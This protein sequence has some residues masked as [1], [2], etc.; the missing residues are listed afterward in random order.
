MLAGPIEFP[1]NLPRSE[2]DK[3]DLLD[4]FA[5]EIYGKIPN[6]TDAF[7]AIPYRI[8]DDTL[9]YLTITM[10]VGQRRF[11]VDAAL[12]IPKQAQSLK[13]VI[14]GLDFVGPAGVLPD[15]SF[16]LDPNARVY[17]RP[18]FGAS[19]GCLAETLRGTSAYR[20]PVQLLLD[21]GYAVLLSC[22]GSWAP[23]CP[24]QII[25]HGVLPLVRDKTAAIS[26]WAW[27]Y[28]R[29]ID[30]IQKLPAVQGSKIAVAGHS[31]LG[32]A[33]LWATAHDP[34]IDAVFANQSGCFGAAPGSHQIGE[35]RSQLVEQFPHWVLPDAP[36]S[37]LDQHQLLSLLAPRKVYLGQAID[38]TWADPLGSYAALIA[39]SRCW[40]A[41]E[42]GDWPEVRDLTEGPFDVATGSVGYHLR[43]GGHDLLPYDWRLFLD[44]LSR[45]DF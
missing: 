9:Q 33:A 14:V 3:T 2:A 37:R 16:Q 39:A 21:H 38:D 34:Q 24:K 25:K 17:S 18:E 6:P 11:S 1:D 41:N 28:M 27:A 44:F 7:S 43:A 31:R 32:K 36:K 8:I 20:W 42:T 40:T 5:S 12:W 10:Q 13:K 23:D 29:L 26:L 19:N 35:T 22:Y 4:R 30:A 15:N 45:S